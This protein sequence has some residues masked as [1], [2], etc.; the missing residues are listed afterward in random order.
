MDF[1]LTLVEKMKASG[2][3]WLPAAANRLE[4]GPDFFRVQPKGH[5]SVV[6]SLSLKANALVAFYH[7]ELYPSWRWG[8]KM[9]AIAITQTRKNLKSYVWSVMVVVL[10]LGH[11]FLD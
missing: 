2:P 10:V 11:T 9:D 1:L 8:E 6:L 4:Q 5:G 7:G 3:P